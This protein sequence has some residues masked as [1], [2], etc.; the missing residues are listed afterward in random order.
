MTDKCTNS[1]TVMYIYDSTITEIPTPLPDTLENLY[2]WYV[3][4]A[5]LPPLPALLCLLDVSDSNI[6]SLPELPASLCVLNVSCTNITSLPELPEGLQSLEIRNTRIRELPATLP[7]HLHILNA[8]GTPIERIVSLPPRLYELDVKNCTRLRV[9]PANMPAS[10]T[11]LTVTGCVSL[12]LRLEPREGVRSYAERW[13][14]W[15]CHWHYRE[16]LIA[17]TWHPRRMLDWCIDEEE[18][19]D[20]MKE[21]RD[22]DYCEHS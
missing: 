14:K 18:R 22:C 7:P 13:R 20:W 10:L 4:V 1:D 17:V 9:L 19:S 16:E 11:W 12:R 15:W 6:T 2:V 8:A 5:A 3:P 21:H